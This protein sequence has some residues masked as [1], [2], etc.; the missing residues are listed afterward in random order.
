MRRTLLITALLAAATLPV[1]H[2]Q[3]TKG[4]GVAGMNVDKV[5]EMGQLTQSELADKIKN[6]WTSVFLVT[7]PSSRTG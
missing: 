2:A 6:G 5:V 1:V 3:V 7:S 4:A